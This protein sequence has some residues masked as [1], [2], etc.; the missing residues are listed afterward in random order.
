MD[1]KFMAQFLEEAAE[2]L[3]V[4]GHPLRIR[5]AQS[6]EDGERK[7]GEIAEAVEAAQS[8][9]SQHL[10]AMRVRGLLNTRREA[11][12]VY[13]S[14]ARPEVYKILD[15]IRESARRAAAEQPRAAA[16]GRR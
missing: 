10:K 16:G 9:T 12:C 11:T 4:M 5:I 3:K 1:E 8:V 6:L 13:Y 14:I 2:M 7:V 15:C